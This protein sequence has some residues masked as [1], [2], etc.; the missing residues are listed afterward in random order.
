MFFRLIDNRAFA[1][2]GLWD[3]WEK[4]E[5]PLD[6]CIVITTEA[7]PRAAM[8]HHR[9]P[10]I[11][12]LDDAE[13]WLN[14]ATNEQ[15]LLELLAPYDKSDLE[16]YEVSRLVNGSADDS[17]DCIAPFKRPPVVKELTLWDM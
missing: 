5:S 16:C 4:G 3:R 11:F 1:I 14:P 15:R 13:E 12:G 17:A 10:A 9:M 2:A 6:T 7:N 8:V